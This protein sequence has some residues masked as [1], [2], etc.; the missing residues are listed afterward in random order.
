LAG[1]LWN[2]C[3]RPQRLQ[4]AAFIAFFNGF[5]ALTTALGGIVSLTAGLL[6]GVQLLPAVLF[7]L[8]LIFV[9]GPANLWI[10]S[11][12]GARRR[13]ALWI[14]LA[15][16]V[17]Q[18]AFQFAASVGFIPTGGLTDVTGDPSAWQAQVI[19]IGLIMLVQV[20]S[21]TIALIAYYA[22]R[23]V[24]GFSPDEAR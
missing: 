5:V 15:N 2:W 8:P 22:N 23:H 10:A 9:F 16:P 13:L 7:F 17:A 12:T 24:P 20:V 6:P 19:T 4:D 11:R 21:F 1:R 18:M 14:G 3:R